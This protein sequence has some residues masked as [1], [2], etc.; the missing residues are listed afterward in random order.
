MWVVNR[1]M[2][3]KEGLPDPSAPMFVLLH[4]EAK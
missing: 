1:L 4:G 3:A 2:P